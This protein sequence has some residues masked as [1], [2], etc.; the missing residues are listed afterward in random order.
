MIAQTIELPPYPT[1]KSLAPALEAFGMV[2]VQTYYRGNSKF[3]YDT[4]LKVTVML[5][6][7]RFRNSEIKKRILIVPF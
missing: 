5:D 4:N 2:G 7:K 1:D 6:Y 3:C